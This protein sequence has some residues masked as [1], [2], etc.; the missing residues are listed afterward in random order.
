MTTTQVASIAP[1]PAAAA[2]AAA[3]SSASRYGFGEDGFT[4]GDFLD[5]IN[6]LQH[7]PVVG[8]IYRAIT[9]DTMEAGSEIAGGALFGGPIGA[10]LATADVAF[11]ADHGKPIDR[12]MLSWI[13]LDG[14]D[15]APTAVVQSA[16]P[17]PAVAAPRPTRVAT[18]APIGPVVPS[19]AFPAAT[20]RIVPLANYQQP[21]PATPPHPAATAAPQRIAPMLID[22]PAD[23]VGTLPASQPRASNMPATSVAAVEP[24]AA[25]TSTPELEGAQA[26]LAALRD[27]G[28]D[29]ASA[30]RAAAAYQ[31]SVTPIVRDPA[32]DT[33]H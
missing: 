33:T 13:G 15:T 19:R 20:T 11:T 22:Q 14:D 31:A 24:V 2:T 9:G 27:S 3:A 30:A 10:L 26:L 7:I 23:T 16:S 1:P 21:P 8:T 28:V 6:P 17:A 12:T 32:T 18:A 29:P 25:A 5:I 4:F